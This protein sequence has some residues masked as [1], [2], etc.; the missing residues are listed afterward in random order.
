M[1]FKFSALRKA[2]KL[3]L[4]KKSLVNFIYRRTDKT[5]DANQQ[6]FNIQYMTEMS[7]F[8]AIKRKNNST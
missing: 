6:A 5:T 2:E 1:Q 3:L 7:F 4:A 8:F